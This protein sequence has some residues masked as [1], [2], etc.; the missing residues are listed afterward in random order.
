MAVKKIRSWISWRNVLFFSLGVIAGLVLPCVSEVVVE[1]VAPSLMPAWFPISAMVV[2]MVILDLLLL[3]LFWCLNRILALGYL[4]VAVP[5]A[6]YVIYDFLGFVSA[7]KDL[8]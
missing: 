1:F 4:L 7:F 8:Y 2:A 3:C 6:I 5:C